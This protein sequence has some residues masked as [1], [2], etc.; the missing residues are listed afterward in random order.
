MPLKAR[1]GAP[2]ALHP[3]IARGIERRKIFLDDDDPLG[4]NPCDQCGLCAEACPARAIQEDG[5]LDAN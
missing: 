4:K 5:T 1:T 3:I 2:E